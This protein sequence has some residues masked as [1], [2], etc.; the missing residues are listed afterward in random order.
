MEKAIIERKIAVYILSD[1]DCALLSVHYFKISLI[2]FDPI[3]HIERKAIFDRFKHG[4]SLLAGINNLPLVLWTNIELAAISDNAFFGAIFIT[5]NHFAN[6]YFVQINFHILFFTFLF[7][8][9]IV[10]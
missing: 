5:G 9:K 8:I 10:K 2:G 3:H 4:I 7:L 6:W 1:A